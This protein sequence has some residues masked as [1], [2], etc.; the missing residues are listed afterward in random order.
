M[1]RAPEIINQ[2]SMRYNTIESNDESPRH[3]K[4][5]LNNSK[6]G[7]I[8]ARYIDNLNK[9][10]KIYESD[11]KNKQFEE[12]IKKNGMND[13]TLSS[14]QNNSSIDNNC[15]TIGNRST[16]TNNLCIIINNSDKTESSDNAKNKNNCND[17]S[18]AEKE[19]SNDINKNNNNE[20]QDNNNIIEIK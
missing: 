18:F 2:Y 9:I 10:E 5:R 6:K 3:V 16:V 20:N 14:I 7:N 8:K 19:K 4:L 13:I 12:M 15:I 17:I 1:L 11:T